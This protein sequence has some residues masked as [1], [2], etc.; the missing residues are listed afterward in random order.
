MILSIFDYNRYINIYMRLT[1]NKN[2]TTLKLTGSILESNIKDLNV[3]FEKMLAHSQKNVVVDFT[4]VNHICSMALGIL[5]SYKKKFTENSGNIK[6]VITDEDLLELF[7]I[8][9]LDKI[10]EIFQDLKSAEDAYKS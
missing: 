3:K 10:F 5:V 6:I 4:E 2:F 1:E 9:M 8:T 7:E